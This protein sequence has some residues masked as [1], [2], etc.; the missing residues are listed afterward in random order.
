MTKRTTGGVYAIT[1]Q[2]TQR[3]YIG[4]SINP[5][6]RMAHHR[7]ALMRHEHHCPDLQ[8]DWDT[9]GPAAFDF[10]LLTP[11]DSPRHDE[12]RIITLHRRA[13]WPLYNH[14]SAAHVSVTTDDEFAAALDTL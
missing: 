7:S 10:L 4:S 12:Q 8:R 13:A 1:C 5:T 14:R 2:H 3:R 9:F 11:S 6:E